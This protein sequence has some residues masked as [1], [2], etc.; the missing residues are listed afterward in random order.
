MKAARSNFLPAHVRSDCQPAR[1]PG[2]P[3]VKV[4]PK[5]YHAAVV[6]SALK[7]EHVRAVEPALFQAFLTV[8]VSAGQ[9]LC[10]VTIV[11]TDPCIIPAVLKILHPTPGKYSM[12]YVKRQAETQRYNYYPSP[13]R[14]IAVL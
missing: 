3:P 5:C 4:H 8:L 9:L 1:S 12:C 11:D 7:D 10:S 6:C 2:H 13:S 14:S